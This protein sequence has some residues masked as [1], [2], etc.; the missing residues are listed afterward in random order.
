MAQQL[1][2]E[3]RSSLPFGKGQEAATADTTA[4]PIEYP[5]FVIPMAKLLSMDALPP[6]QHCLANGIL[7]PWR[8]EMSGRIVRKPDTCLRPLPCSNLK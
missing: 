7:E 3:W 6:H 5:M 1:F 2:K 4:V 8:E